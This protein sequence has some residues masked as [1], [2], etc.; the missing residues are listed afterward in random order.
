[1]AL[2]PGGLLLAGRVC[3]RKSGKSRG[4]LWV[5]SGED[6]KKQAEHDLDSP[7]AYDGLAIAG[8]QAYLAL[9]DGSVVCFG[10]Q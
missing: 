4:F 9:E 1:M 8:G 3:E 5:V 7:P 6:G 2:S 10:R